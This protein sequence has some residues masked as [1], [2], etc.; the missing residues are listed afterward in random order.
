MSHFSRVKITKFRA[1]ALAVHPTVQ[2]QIQ[3]GWLKKL[4]D[5][6]DLDALDVLHAVD[7]PINGKR[8]PYI[9]DGQHRYRAL[10]ERGMGEWEVDVKI[11]L[12]VKS[13][14]RA[15]ELIKLLNTRRTFSP[16]D[17][18]IQEITAGE[19]VAVGIMDI[20]RKYGLN[21]SRSS[22]DGCVACPYAL[23]TAYRHDDGRALDKAIA[24]LVQSF[25]KCAAALEG[26]VIEGLALVTAVN[27]GNLDEPSLVK[28]LAKHSGGASALIAKGKGRME[29]HRTSLAR[30][31]AGYIIDLY[32]VGRRADKL[33]AL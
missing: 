11:Y 3:P 6:L 9:I 21:L 24:I 23:K 30:S 18:F 16:Y 4:T 13:D 15:A 27:N 2:R 25:G 20:L 5:N 19:F 29:F 31:I 22:G 17:M 8:G 7:Y 28:K 12:D 32:N 26:K 33:E 14:K 1:D 10:I